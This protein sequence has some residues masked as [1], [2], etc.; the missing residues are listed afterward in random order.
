MYG[1]FG[2]PA[3]GAIG[4]GYATALVWYL[5]F[6]TL[7]LYTIFSKKYKHLVFFRHFHKPEIR[8][9]KEILKLG[10]PLSLTIGMEILMFAAVGL[11]I[12]R[13]SIN[14]I[15]AHQIAIN[16]VSITYLIASGIASATTIR[17]SNLMGLG[18]NEDVRLAARSG[19]KITFIFMVFASLIFLRIS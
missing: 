4:L 18:L 10:L 12:G 14:I 5:I 16:L 6:T 7:L 9:F 13:Y 11:F 19:M 3:L 17:V 2:L 1:Y 8:V 15:A